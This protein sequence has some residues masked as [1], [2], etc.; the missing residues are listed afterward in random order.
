MAVEL[1]DNWRQKRQRA[2]QMLSQLGLADRVDYKPHAL[3]GGQ[4]SEWRS[5]VL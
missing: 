1:L 3:S 5:P 2:V 4:N